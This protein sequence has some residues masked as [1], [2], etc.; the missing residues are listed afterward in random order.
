MLVANVSEISQLLAISLAAAIYVPH[1][2]PQH[3][4]SLVISHINESQFTQ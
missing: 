4:K 1:P 3:K 2:S